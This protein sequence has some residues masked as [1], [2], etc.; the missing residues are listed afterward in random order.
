MLK[1]MK[2]NTTYIVFGLFASIAIAVM[3]NEGFNPFTPLTSS[4]SGGAQN[5]PDG[6]IS[7]THILQM[8]PVR[9]YTLMGVITSK[10]SQIALVRASNGEEYFVRVN[11]SIGDSNGVI[12]SITKNGIEVKEADKMVSLKVRNR[13]VRND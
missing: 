11:D 4:S 5:A 6:T 3:A 2:N 12:K 7:S 10:N 1:I 8:L 13:G 9:N